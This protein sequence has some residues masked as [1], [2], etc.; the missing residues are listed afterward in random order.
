MRTTL[1]ARAAAL[2]LAALAL[3]A[4]A[5]GDKGNDG[6]AAPAG[7]TAAK[8]SVS[9]STPTVGLSPRAGFTYRINVPVTIQE[10][11]G[12]GANIDRLRLALIGGGRTLETQDIGSADVIAVTGSNRLAAGGTR[13]FTLTFDVNAGQATSG[14]LTL[15]FTDDLRNQ[16]SADF[17]IAF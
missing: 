14:L 2:G 12:V 10:S 11:A 13:S 5:C 6:P 9:A 17:T 1:Q 7:P 15:F 16:L 8:I 4:G 3:I